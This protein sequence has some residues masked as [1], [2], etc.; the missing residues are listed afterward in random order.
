MMLSTLHDD[1]RHFVPARHFAAAFEFLRDR[2][3]AKLEPGRYPI[4]GDHV[5]AIV[6]KESG[7]RKDKAPLEVHRAHLDIHFL[8][9]GSETLGWKALAD[10]GQPL[11][12]FN[13][14]RDIQFFRDKPD[15]WVTLTP[16]QFTV[17]HPADC[18]APGVGSGTIHKV[19]I[20]I[21]V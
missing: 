5:R 10:C 6:S 1:I 12:R 15:L 18:H 9:A 2:N 20:K 17:F 16:G 13:T 4:L 3:L 14:A 7:R 21:R 19:V 8:I 11:A